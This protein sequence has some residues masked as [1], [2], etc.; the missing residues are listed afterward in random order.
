[1][2]NKAGV[3]MVSATVTNNYGVSSTGASSVTI[4]PA[5][6]YITSPPS[7]TTMVS[8]VHVTAYAVS[9]N[10]IAAIKV[11]LDYNEVYKTTA[12][13]V[14]ISLAMGAGQHLLVTNAWD[15]TGALMQ[16]QA[17]ITVDGGP[18]AA[19]AVSMSGATATASTSASTDASAAITSSVINWGDGI[20]SPGPTATHTYARGGNYSVTA[21]VMDSLGLSASKSA[22][23]TAAGV[24]IWKPANGATASSPVHVSATAYDSKKIASMT[25]YVDASKKYVIYSAS[26]DTY[27]KIPNSGKHTILVRA[28]E[29]V[30]GIVYQSSVT[31]TLP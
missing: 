19:L 28:W 10:P 18:M 2:Y 30:T 29:D 14:D 16:A 3:Y 22:P 8:P 26:L 1:V 6:I 11:Y 5:A 20:S 25:V 17:N 23:V 31:V 21:T 24:V 4:D 27:I 12:N 15:S 7:G 9:G 13:T